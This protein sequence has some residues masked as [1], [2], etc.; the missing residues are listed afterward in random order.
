[1]AHWIP[2]PG[3]NAGVGDWIT[4]DMLIKTFSEVFP[5]SSMLKSQ[6]FPGVHVL[7]SFEKIEFSKDDLEVRLAKAEIYED[8]NEWEEVS[9]D[10]FLGLEPMPSEFPPG[11]SMVTDDHPN[12]EFYLMRRWRAGHTKMHRTLWWY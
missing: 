12:L 2:F 1:M 10:Y 4:F 3:S 11:T 7:G 8:M 9:A 6:R 5:Y